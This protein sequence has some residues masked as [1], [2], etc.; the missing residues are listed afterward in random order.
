MFKNVRNTR[1]GMH[2]LGRET[3]GVGWGV[4]FATALAQEALGTRQGH[5]SEMH[6]C[7]RLPP[8]R[9]PPVPYPLGP[10][11]NEVCVTSATR[12]LDPPS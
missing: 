4:T 12:H 9:S 1:Q 10:A 8:Q 11:C 7:H 6:C 2:K 5:A 3:G